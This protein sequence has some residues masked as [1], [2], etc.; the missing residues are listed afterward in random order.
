MLPQIDMYLIQIM[1]ENETN[2]EG[3]EWDIWPEKRPTFEQII[4]KSLQS[5]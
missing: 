2:I 4:D 3:I 5:N 1:M